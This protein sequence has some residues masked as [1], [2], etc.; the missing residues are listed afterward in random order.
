M[1]YQLCGGCRAR[2][3][4]ENALL[5]KGEFEIHQEVLRVF[6]FTYLSSSENW[7]DLTL[8]A[9]SNPRPEILGR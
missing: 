7:K 8:F 6:F 9:K 1:A 2:K 5:T 4:Y 3:T